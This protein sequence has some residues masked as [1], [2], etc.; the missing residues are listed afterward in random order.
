MNKFI[1][2][3]TGLLLLVFGCSK[4]TPTSVADPSWVETYHSDYEII[5]VEYDFTVFTP[6]VQ[7]D[8]TSGAATPSG[9][10]KARAQA[11]L[12]NLDTTK[13]EHYSGRV[14]DEASG[15]YIYDCSG[16][17]GDFVIRQVL[18]D[19]YQDLALF[20]N[21]FHTFDP[22]PRAWGFYDYF[23]DILGNDASGQA[24]PVGQNKYWKVFIAAD[25][26]KKGDIIV[27]KYDQDWR[28]QYQDRE[29][30]DAST[31]HV[32]IAWSQPIII[33]SEATIRILD[34]A[35]SGHYYDT[36]DSANT[37]SVDGSGIG[38]GWMR[39][40]LSTNGR[41]RPY[42]YHWKLGGHWYGLWTG[43]YDYYNRLE[44]ILIARPI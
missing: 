42:K 31:G 35:S 21:A 1:L 19:H 17:V 12:D 23:R 29:N 8:D 39:Y 15:T 34:C 43:S 40:G 13:Y 3:I 10:F 5:P 26:I 22:R 16:L 25:S 37:A 4:E 6:P 20:A 18:Y 24:N 14:M 9:I 11:I 33:G 7:I 27:V 44:G 38:V 36:R 32:M 41:N 28:K 2:S 30:K